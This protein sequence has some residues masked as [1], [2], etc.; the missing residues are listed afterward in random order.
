[1]HIYN[2]AKLTKLNQQQLIYHGGVDGV[3]N[4]N[5][6]CSLTLLFVGEPVLLKVVVEPDHL[7]VKRDILLCGQDTLRLFKINPL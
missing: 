1:M 3:I 4:G 7:L 5:Y 6:R 2:E